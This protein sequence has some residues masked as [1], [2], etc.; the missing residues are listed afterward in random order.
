MVLRVTEEERQLILL[1][2]AELSLSRPGWDDALRRIAVGLFGE[3]I[4]IE[5]M[6]LN[7]DRVKETHG[8]LRPL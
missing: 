4:Y 5:L 2:L 3:A 1:A 6:R 8:R 7:A